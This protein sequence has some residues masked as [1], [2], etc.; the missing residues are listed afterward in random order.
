VIFRVECSMDSG[1]FQIFGLPTVLDYRHPFP[2]YHKYLS[3]LYNQICV[4]K[5]HFP[6]FILFS[7]TAFPKISFYIS[8]RGTMYQW[9]W[10]VPEDID[11]WYRDSAAQCCHLYRLAVHP[12][13]LLYTGTCTT[14]KTL[15]TSVFNG[16]YGWKL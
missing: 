5:V 4:V 16:Q 1:Y 13:R 3:W 2:L 15:D 11:T 6:N 12:L 7:N 9:T 14:T 8:F 10:D